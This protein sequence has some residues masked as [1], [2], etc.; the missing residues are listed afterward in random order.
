MACDEQIHVIAE[1]IRPLARQESVIGDRI[2]EIGE[3][4]NRPRR[5]KETESANRFT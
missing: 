3:Q 2:H 5:S 4:R 1:R